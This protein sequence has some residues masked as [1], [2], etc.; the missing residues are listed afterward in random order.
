M[1]R[2]QD[3]PPLAHLPDLPSKAQLYSLAI[4]F[5]ARRALSKHQLETRLRRYIMHQQAGRHKTQAHK[6][7]QKDHLAPPPKAK[8]LETAHNKDK[9]E[10]LLSPIIQEIITELEQKQF[11]NDDS[12][13]LSRLTHLWQRG[14]SLPAMWQKLHQAGLSLDVIERALTQLTTRH[15][16]DK[17]PKAGDAPPNPQALA[18]LELSAAQHYIKRRQ[19]K[20]APKADKNGQET[21]PLELESTPSR[22]AQKPKGSKLSQSQRNYARLRRAGF[23]HDSAQK[24]LKTLNLSPPTSLLHRD[25]LDERDD[26]DLFD[27]HA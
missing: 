5:L 12:Y 7:P 1:P 8:D 20:F 9:I 11:L 14:H 24:A 15:L 3:D 4:A 18:A 13:S 6:T 26:F 27:L 25:G 16:L 17:N 19:H 22:S 2:L 23:S 21:A 10:K